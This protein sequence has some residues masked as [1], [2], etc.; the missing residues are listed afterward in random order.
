MAQLFFSTTNF[1]H[2][3]MPSDQSS[4]PKRLSSSVYNK[5]K[6]RNISAINTVF[7]MKGMSQIKCGENT[8]H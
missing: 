2:S 5:Y 6:I 3:D 1:K 8:V 7:L 4:D